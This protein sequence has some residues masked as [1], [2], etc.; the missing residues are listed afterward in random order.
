LCSRLGVLCL[1]EV[2]RAS[3]ICEPWPAGQ[4]RHQRRRC[5]YVAS[6]TQ[7]HATLSHPVRMG[8]ISIFSSFSPCPAS[9]PSTGSSRFARS[10]RG[11]V[12]ARINTRTDLFLSREGRR[13]RATRCVFPEPSAQLET[14]AA[15]SSTGPLRIVPHRTLPAL[16][17]AI[18]SRHLSSSNLTRSGE[19][20]W[21]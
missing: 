19:Q 15:P 17:G 14:T 20:C 2:S 18:W 6:S 12:H 16:T 10:K 21:V 13:L 1:F 9:R 3:T 5:T 11:R 8:S 4:P 7:H